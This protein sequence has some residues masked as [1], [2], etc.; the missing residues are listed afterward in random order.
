[1]GGFDRGFDRG[2]G[3]DRDKPTEVAAVG[4]TIVRSGEH[5]VAVETRTRGEAH[6]DLR[7]AAESGWE[8]GRG[9]GAPRGELAAFRAERAGLSEVSSVEAAR[10]VDRHRGERPW[11]VVAERASP[12]AARII[13]AADQGGG[14]G[15]IRHEG[16]VTEEASMR[17]V[18]YLEDPAQLDPGKRRAGID[19]LRPRS[20]H[21]G[22]GD[23]SSRIADPDAFAT[24][25]AR[26]AGHPDVRAALNTPYDRSSS[27]DPVRIPVADL[28]GSDGHKAC[29]GWQLEPVAGS[30]DVARFN[31]REWRAAIADGRQPD[32]PE[33]RTSPVPTF[34]DGAIAFV[35]GHNRQ[36]NGYEIASLFPQPPIHDLPGR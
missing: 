11:L 9:F 26:G 25:L 34:E 35:I 15:H 10:Y 13:V 33:P 8:R 7:Q 20:R 28:L 5:R 17:R 3:L 12:E 23:M 32:V 6:A 27:P 24:A 29:T 22:C 1:V 16:W 18:A 21:H 14:H 4:A 30:I 36:R 19:G 31:R 2:N